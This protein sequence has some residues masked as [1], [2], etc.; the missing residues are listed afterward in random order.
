MADFSPAP[1]SAPI[2][3]IVSSR[4]GRVYVTTVLAAMR[5]FHA[6]SLTELALGE[7]VPCRPG[8]TTAKA[9]KRSKGANNVTC[10]APALQK[11]YF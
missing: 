7:A 8:G 6:T 5:G 4:Y 3:K 1:A 2:E 10:T 11:K 9:Y